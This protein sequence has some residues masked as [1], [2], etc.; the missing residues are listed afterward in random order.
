MRDFNPCAALG[1]ILRRDQRPDIFSKRNEPILKFY[2]SSA[3]KSTEKIHSA[4][5]DEILCKINFYFYDRIGQI[6]NRVFFSR[7]LKFVEI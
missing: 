7:M 1:T 6:I 3:E 5:M 4:E 2:E